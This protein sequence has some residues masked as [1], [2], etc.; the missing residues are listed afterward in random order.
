[1]NTIQLINVISKDEL[2]R[3]NFCGVLPI[4]HLPIKNLTHDCSFIINTDPSTERGQH[5]VA[6][7]APLNGDIEYFDSYGFKTNK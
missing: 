3:K 7:F 2:A 1:M 4:D 6:I 5:W